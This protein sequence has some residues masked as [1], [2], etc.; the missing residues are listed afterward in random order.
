MFLLFYELGFLDGRVIETILGA[1]Y[2][3]PIGTCKKRMIR[4]LEIF[5]YGDVYGKC[6]CLC[7]CI[8]YVHM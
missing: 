1:V 7:C 5:I 8:E 4:S 6:L 3:I 2:G